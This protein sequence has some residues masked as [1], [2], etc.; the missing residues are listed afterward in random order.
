M[1]VLHGGGDVAVD[2]DDG[3]VELGEALDQRRLVLLGLGARAR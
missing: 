3:L 2:E 1:H